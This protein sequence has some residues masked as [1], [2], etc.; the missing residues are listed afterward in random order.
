V[1]EARRFYGTVLGFHF[2]VINVDAI[3]VQEVLRQ[4]ETKLIVS[5]Q[6]GEIFLHDRVAPRIDAERIQDRGEVNLLPGDP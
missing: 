4:G 1:G 2:E 5:F 6:I 3:A